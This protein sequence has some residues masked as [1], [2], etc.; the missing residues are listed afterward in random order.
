MD[1]QRT[2]FILKNQPSRLDKLWP[3]KGKGYEAMPSG[4][5]PQELKAETDLQTL[6]LELEVL[7]KF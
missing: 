6:L 7:R 3:L 1:R 5:S 2:S 4:E